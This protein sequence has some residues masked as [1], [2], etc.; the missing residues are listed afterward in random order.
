[1]ISP[2]PHYIPIKYSINTV[3]IEPRSN[4]SV[5]R[6]SVFWGGSDPNFHGPPTH[7]RR[8]QSTPEFRGATKS[9]DWIE[10]HQIGEICLQFL[11]FFRSCYAIQET[12]R[13]HENSWFD[14]PILSQITHHIP[15][16]PEVLE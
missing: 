11:F 14:T 8:P 6:I 5:Q 9:P 4:P 12:L 3:P 1:M 2:Y 16:L 10:N 7:L 15:E 13:N